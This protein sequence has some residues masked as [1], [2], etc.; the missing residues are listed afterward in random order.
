[1]SLYFNHIRVKSNSFL[2][3]LLWLRITIP[4]NSHALWGRLY[5]RWLDRGGHYTHQWI[6]SLMNSLA[7]GV[8]RKWGLVRSE[9]LRTRARRLCFPPSSSLLSLL[10]DHHGVCIIHPLD[11]HPLY[12]GCDGWAAFLHPSPSIIPF[13]SWSHPIMDYNCEPK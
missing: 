7:E 10:P 8:T 5:G 13:L 3:H 9:S 2:L 11:P 4:Q 12:P 1:M 6:H